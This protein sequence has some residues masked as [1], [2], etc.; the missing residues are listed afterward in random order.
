MRHD[1]RGLR[2]RQAVIHGSVE[3]N[4]EPALP[5]LWQ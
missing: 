3:V 1:L 4:R 5:A 2:L